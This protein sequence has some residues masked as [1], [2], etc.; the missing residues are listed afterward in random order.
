MSSDHTETIEGY[1]VDLACLRKYPHDALL[2]RA[3]IHTRACALMAHC[4]ES[5]YGLVADDGRVLPLDI[6]ATPHVYDALRQSTND[7]GIR[8]R[9][10]RI[11]AGEEMKTSSVELL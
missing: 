7:R 5:G 6:E 9:V 11:A 8:A 2:A 10:R 3:R 1:V 4:V